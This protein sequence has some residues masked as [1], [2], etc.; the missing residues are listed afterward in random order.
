[1]RR[2]TRG[3]DGLS[4][5]SSAKDDQLEE[6]VPEP[7]E[8]S[9]AAPA[10]A[11]AEPFS[12]DREQW[13]D[14]KKAARRHRHREIG[15]QAA[16]LI[17]IAIFLVW[18]GGT[19]YSFAVPDYPWEDYELA[20]NITI[21]VVASVSAVFAAWRARVNGARSVVPV[22]SGEW[23]PPEE[24][25]PVD[26]RV[27]L[28]REIS[29]LRT[30]RFRA[31]LIA[32]GW[33]AVHIGGFLGMVGVE[34]SAAELLETGAQVP[35]RVASLHD[36]DGGRGGRSMEVN[37][38]VGGRRYNTDV[39]LET[40]QRYV[41]G[42][43]VTVVYDRSEPGRMR[44]LEE[45]NENQFWVGVSVTVAIVALIAVPFSLVAAG[46]W[47]RRHRS[48]L[49]TGWRTAS[50]TVAPD[51]PIRSG[52]KMPSIEVE[53]RDGSRITL[54]ASTSTHGST[55]LRKR[56]KRWAWVGGEGR[57]MVVLFPHGRW[58]EPPYA[59]PAWA[60]TERFQP[61]EQATS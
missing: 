28:E 4:L 14:V 24:D 61:D 57:D 46:A 9:S 8:S 58:R 3:R 7:E 50:V 30:L 59:V 12:L 13:D 49:A 51:Y 22:G 11:R 27:D 35:G 52:R 44:T 26:N 38:V 40:D 41:T 47:R 55:P 36:P 29:R 21:L 56:P 19:I 2:R 18:T 15:Y 43:S 54:R 34:R 1:M 37:Y 39:S 32:L 20:A 42:E 17:F 45:P 60:V 16:E 33:A 48:V 10:R 53:Y 23:L 25:L 5:W 31:F 6:H